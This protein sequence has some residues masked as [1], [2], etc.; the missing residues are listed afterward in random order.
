MIVAHRTKL[1]AL[2]N[3]EA[4]LTSDITAVKWQIDTLKNYSSTHQIRAWNQHKKYLTRRLNQV[5]RDIKS[6]LTRINGEA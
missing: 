6:L 2:Q 1:H 5:R 4:A 3:N